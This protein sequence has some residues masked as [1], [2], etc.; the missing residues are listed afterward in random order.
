MTPQC[1]AAER[2]DSGGGLLR[3]PGAKLSP[4]SSPEPPQLPAPRWQHRSRVP[5]AP[6]EAVSHVPRSHGR[7]RAPSAFGVPC[8]GAQ[9]PVWEPSPRSRVLGQLGVVSALVTLIPG[10]RA[11]PQP[12]HHISGGLPVP[13]TAPHP[14]GSAPRAPFPPVPCGPCPAPRCPAEPRLCR[15]PRSSRCPRCPR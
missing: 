1:R 8:T 2:E 11:H 4:S 5:A 13:S 7:C 6:C 3:L 15:Q 14:V 12:S 10:L 9:V